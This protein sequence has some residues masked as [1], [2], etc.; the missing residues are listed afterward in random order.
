MKY[1]I[2]T[3]HRADNY[4]AVLQ[5]FA[6]E[7]FLNRS[8]QEAEIIDYRN[9]D[10]EDNYSII[11]IH[12]GE[13]FIK[14]IARVLLSGIIQ[15]K[16]NQ[17]FE[18]FRKQNLNLS[19][20]CDSRGIRNLTN[21]YDYVITGSDQVFAPKYSGFDKIY[22]LS[23]VCEDEK[24]ISYA[25]SFGTD[26]LTDEVIEWISSEVK[27]FVS[28]SI[29]EKSG[30][31]ELERVFQIK[32]S[33]N[34]DPIFLIG[35]DVW[36]NLIHNVARRKYILIFTINNSNNVIK[37]AQ[38]LSKQTGYDILYLNDKYYKRYD[39]IRYEVACSPEDFLSLFYHA[40]YIITTSFH[41][42]AFS[43]LFH[44][45]FLVDLQL[46]ENK[47]DRL[48]ALFE[49]FNIF[50]NTCQSFLKGSNMIIHDWSTV[51]RIIREE[52]IRSKEYF[53]I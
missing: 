35:V 26:H 28:I 6:L 47:G 21:K 9:K 12:K 25:A 46:G 51:D 29:R 37:A 45:P 42:S 34:I 20:A 7:E 52:Q 13:N 31:T 3:Y 5:A 43:I 24:K 22:L 4:G 30:I 50:P 23:N 19:S 40:E 41:G 32:A 44:K 36:S 16:R 17:K 38:E 39:G 33:Q 1:G 8:G 18:S 2:I 49:K 27:K 11:K 14:Y 53:H 10:I 15:M 48:R